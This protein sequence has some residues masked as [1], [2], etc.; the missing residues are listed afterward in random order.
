M[1]NL[2]DFP[3]YRIDTTTGRVYS[4]RT[5]GKE[6]EIRGCAAGNKG[7][8]LKYQVITTD[9]RVFNASIGRLIAAAQYGCSYFKLPKDVM[10]NW[11]PE[12]GL[13]LRDRRENALRGHEG[14]RRR[15]AE[16]DRLAVLDRTIN[17]MQLIRQA[18]LGDSE[19]FARYVFDHRDEYV[20][21]TMTSRLSLGVGGKAGI[22]SAVGTAI[23]ML[24]DN[25]LNGHRNILMI[26][27]WIIKTALCIIKDRK[28]HGHRFVDIESRRAT[29]MMNPTHKR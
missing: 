29:F 11:T 12:G 15:E 6:R 17:E 24:I 28:A 18:Y 2:K 7:S 13:T 1:Y 23:D 26:E 9:G 20:R 5:K 19:P 27:P 8:Q 14:L 3:D 21:R 4:Y 22:E 25:V 10:F 16:V